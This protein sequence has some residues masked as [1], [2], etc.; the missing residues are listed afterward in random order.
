MKVSNPNCYNFEKLS[1]LPQAIRSLQSLYNNGYFKNVFLTILKAVWSISVSYTML[2]TPC[3]EGVYLDIRNQP[4][5]LCVTSF[6]KA[7]LYCMV[8]FPEEK[9]RPPFLV[10]RKIHSS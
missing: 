2:Y 10:V 3:F 9:F 7:G 6:L 1:V 8:D 5:C 4:G